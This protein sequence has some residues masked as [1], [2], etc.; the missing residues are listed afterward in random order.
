M[1]TEKVEKRTADLYDDLWND[2][3]KKDFLKYK[4]R[5]R[6]TIPESGYTGKICLDAGCGQGAI[7]SIMSEK[8]K[9]VYSVD[10]GKKALESAR[11]NVKKR[12]IFKKSSLL[13][14]PFPDNKFEFVVSNGVIHHTDNPAKALNELKRVLMPEGTLLLGLYGKTG[15]LRY[16]IE[17]TSILLKWVPYRII[18]KILVILGFNPLMR[19]YILDYIYVPVRK[20]FSIKKIKS[21]MDGFSDL[22][23]TSDYPKGRLNR[24]IYGTNYFY[25]T[26]RKHKKVYK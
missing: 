22:R 15:I 21:M 18:K 23:V 13:N 11:K 17:I 6:K 12:V 9:E 14:L 19:Y 1:N 5:L 16:V 4:L 3:T 2:L 25:I 7:T 8:A 10:I 26:A 24:I 20:R